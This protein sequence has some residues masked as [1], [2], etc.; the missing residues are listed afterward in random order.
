MPCY[1]LTLVKRN[2]VYQLFQMI[3]DQY[4]QDASATPTVNNITS[5]GNICPADAWPKISIQ[6]SYDNCVSTTGS[7]VPS[8]AQ[9][10]NPVMIK[11]GCAGVSGLRWAR[12]LMPG[13]YIEMFLD[14]KSYVNT[15]R[16]YFIC[17]QMDGAQIAVDLMG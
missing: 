8:T 13:D 17:E 5:G 12:Q 6:A 10:A 4:P 1:T 2:T 14:G 16:Q 11:M 3:V 15:K 7:A 9:N